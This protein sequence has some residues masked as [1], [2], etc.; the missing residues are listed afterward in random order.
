MGGSLAVAALGTLLSNRLAAELQAHLGAAAAARVDTDRLLAGGASTP[1]G[2][3]AG[4]QAALS[5]ALHVVFVA[6]VPLGILA[7]V[8]ALALP[9]LPLRTWPG[10]DAPAPARDEAVSLS[11]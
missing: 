3:S 7:L 11:R 4:V 9:E 8:L 1:S 2:V 6:S 10:R 5:D